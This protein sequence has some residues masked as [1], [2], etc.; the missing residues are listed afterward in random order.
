MTYSGIIIILMFFAMV[1]SIDEKLL[2]LPHALIKN[3]QL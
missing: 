2:A 3:S 1:V